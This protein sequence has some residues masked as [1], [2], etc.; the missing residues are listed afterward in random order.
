MKGANSMTRAVVIK[1]VGDPRIAGAIVDGMN[2]NIE[3]L[4][5]REYKALKTELARL[6]QVEARDAVRAYGDSVR[7]ETVC[8]ALEVKYS[9]KSHGRIYG[10]IVGTWAY[11]WDE[12]LSMSEYLSGVK[13]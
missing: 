10:A 6:R 8:K 3:P 4:N 2:R 1:T 11:I 12:L 5:E 7:W 13:S 9:T